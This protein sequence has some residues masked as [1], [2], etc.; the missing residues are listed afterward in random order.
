[1]RK[2]AS[3]AL[4]LEI[5]GFFRRMEL[6]C[7]STRT[8]VLKT[9]R[10]DMTELQSILE[11]LPEH[12]SVNRYNLHVIYLARDPRGILNS[13]RALPSQWPARL[14]SPLHICSRLLND[15]VHISTH[16]L[17]KI[18]ILKYEDL[19]SQPS[20][21]LAAIEEKFNISLT[22]KETRKFLFDHSSSSANWE[23]TNDYRSGKWG[24]HKKMR[25]RDEEDPVKEVMKVVAKGKELL[26]EDILLEQK[27]KKEQ[28]VLLEQQLVDGLEGSDYY[29]NQGKI[30]TVR[31]KKRK[32]SEK[33]EA[34]PTDDH[35]EASKDPK[36]AKR[37]RRKIKNIGDRDPQGRSFY[38][39]T[40]RGKD[41]SPDHWRK[42]LPK[43]LL[44][45]VAK[46]P[47]CKEVM[48]KFGY[49]ER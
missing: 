41:F 31:R 13:V 3:S 46:E 22:S 14:L 36:N 2:E 16:N 11:S 39:S 33:Q 29:D 38:Y 47:A 12:G 24:P 34:R 9:I 6:R 15:S 17:T 27:E 20:E 26:E 21:E 40:Y 28:D 44:D 23:A 8:R 18:T 19:A 35:G 45:E 37:Q 48:A 32:V 1:M 30:A 5:S 25:R 49:P 4:A 42:Q 7:R 10:L 43:K